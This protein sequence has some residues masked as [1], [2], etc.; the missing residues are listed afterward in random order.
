M[1]IIL[2][3]LQLVYYT[4]FMLLVYVL[5]GGIIY[6]ISLRLL[7]AVDEQDMEL[8]R[9]F[10]GRRLESVSRFLSWVLIATD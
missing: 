2:F 3:A 6:I 9:G 4:K 1:A 7:K 5:V 10:L 8:V